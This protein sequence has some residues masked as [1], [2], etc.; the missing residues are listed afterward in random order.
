MLLFVFYLF[1]L[2][3]LSAS[4]LTGL[5]IAGIVQNY[6]R[7][8]GRRSVT[9][10]YA[11]ET[12]D[13][14]I[15]NK[16]ALQSAVHGHAQTRVGSCSRWPADGDC[17]QE[18]LAQVEASPENVDRLMTKWYAGK[19]CAICARE[20]TP[21][22]WRQSRVAVL[23]REQKLLELRQLGLERLQV[24]LE[25]TRPLC[26]NCHQEERE[27]QGGAVRGQLVTA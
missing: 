7:N 13:V 17:G 14:V 23:N 15:D 11:P 4:L 8:R 9:C 1:L 10:P 25:N 5:P 2:F 22:D 19:S 6:Y 27:R 3:L 24:A 12:A 18:C 26:W 20:L 21:A 16:F